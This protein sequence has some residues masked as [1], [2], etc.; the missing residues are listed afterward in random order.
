MK[1]TKLN[2]LTCLSS[3]SSLSTTFLLL[4]RDRF[5][6]SS[7]L[8]IN[9]VKTSHTPVGVNL[10]YALAESP[11]CSALLKAVNGMYLC[12]LFVFLTG[13]VNKPKSQQI[14]SFWSVF[15]CRCPAITLK[16]SHCEP[17]SP[18]S[19]EN[20]RRS[21]NGSR[22]IHCAC[23]AITVTIDGLLPQHHLPVLIRRT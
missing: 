10:C 1:C 23:S 7:P 17:C 5:H 12:C 11:C 9:T 20:V 8:L 13:S 19:P 2:P 3:L 4:S 21:R 15:R 14:D 16:G 6:S 18:L 22:R